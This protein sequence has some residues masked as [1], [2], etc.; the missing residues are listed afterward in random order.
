[1]ADATL[2]QW[3][4]NTLVQGC[5]LGLGALALLAAAPRL[6]RRYAPQWFCRVWAVLAVLLV[7]PLGSLPAWRQKA[8][9]Q[10]KTP[11][12]W[13]QPLAA[14]VQPEPLNRETQPAA[15]APA[16]AAEAAQP[17]Q[18]Q[19]SQPEPAAATLTLPDPLTLLAGV[20][21]GG[22]AAFLAWQGLA[23]LVWRH[24]ALGHARPAAGSWAEAWTHACDRVPLGR[25][26]TL[27][28]TPAVGVP[29]A[30]GLLRPVVLVPLTDPGPVAARMMLLHERTH[31]QRRDLALK[32]LLLLARALHWYNPAV[33]LLC[34]RAARDLEAACDAQVVAG[35]DAPW[36]GAYGEALL[37]AAR[38]GRAPAFTT[39]FA[40]GKKDL[41]FRFAR[42]WDAGPRRR[43]GLALVSVGLCAAL[44]AGLIACTPAETQ[45]PTTAETS[46]AA[47]TTR[48]AA[49]PVAA[50]PD[51]SGTAERD[52]AM[53]STLNARLTAPVPEELESVPQRLYSGTQLEDRVDLAMADGEGGVDFWHSEDKG[54]TYTQ[55]VLDLTPLLG[56]GPFRVASYERL[57]PDTAFLVI[58]R[59]SEPNPGSMSQNNLCIL[60]QNGGDWQ[61]MSEQTCPADTDLGG[62]HT[63][64]FFWL[65]ENVGFWSPH[66]D[67]D[68]LNLWRTIDGG[69]TWQAL[70]LSG[71]EELLPFVE[72]PGLHTCWAGSDPLQPARGSVA[73]HAYAAK[74]N[75]S[76][77]QEFWLVS[78]DY[79]ETWRV[80]A[81][82]T[83][84][85]GQQAPA[86]LTQE[87]P[88]P[89]EEDALAEEVYS[90]L[91]DCLYLNRCTT[92]DPVLLAWQPD[93]DG[94][95]PVQPGTPNTLEGVYAKAADGLTAQSVQAGIESTMTDAALAEL[96]PNWQQG[97]VPMVTEL[98][99][100]L[101]IRCERAAD[102]NGDGW[103]LN[104]GFGYRGEKSYGSGNGNGAG[105]GN[106]NGNGNGG[107][108]DTLRLRLWQDGL[109]SC[110]DLHLR[111]DGSCWRLDSTEE[112]LNVPM[113]CPLCGGELEQRAVDTAEGGLEKQPCIHQAYGED[114][115]Y[116]QYT[117]YQYVCTDCGQWQSDTWQEANGQ[118][119]MICHGYQ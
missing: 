98:D 69:I 18:S 53:L 96:F 94:W 63:Q 85:G 10:L 58:C 32:G 107:N 92:G 41:K 115:L 76:G 118:Q 59:E 20:W 108:G 104:G 23:Y 21:L 68:A 61:L 26:V 40:P 62:W 46:S 55:S 16:A 52:P 80:R 50:V 105:N 37:A 103:W 100:Q 12:A 71:M 24:K 17:A 81:S 49:E 43:G 117:V 5:V 91:Q 3:F 11:V 22:G 34:R 93:G 27:R 13:Q 14:P 75:Y 86:W 42:L 99:G 57:T 84:E 25:P 109:G 111:R 83:Q 33:I 28:Q 73:V 82:Y 66:T 113:N 48:P 116:P 56:D 70:D 78:S 64:T 77:G 89:Q 51:R 9:V 87:T 119:R 102:L 19:T 88:L 101:Y 39:G 47:P 8:P 112:M 106:G 1:M 44:C 114:Y 15:Q 65:N 31:L 35:H 54:E 4:L 2:S 36:R 38:M 60:R 29:V 110:M 90:R 7:L 6:G 30:A 72:I 74:G 95:V 79:G 45:A 97:P 67:Y